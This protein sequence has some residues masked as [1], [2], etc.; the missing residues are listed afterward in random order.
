MR[1]GL[2]GAGIET[3]LSPALHEQEGRSHGLD[4]TYTLI[5]ADTGLAA[6]LERAEA[7]GFVGVNITHPFKQ[8]AV[9]LVDDLSPQA[10]EIGAVNTVV[11]DDG[12][13]TGHNTDVHGF[14]E[15]FRLNLPGAARD[16]V[17]LLGAG[18]AGAACAFAL[19]GLGVGHLTVVDP[20]PDRRGALGEALAARFDADRIALSAPDRLDPALRAA[21]GLVNASPVGM[22]SHPGLPLPVDLL[23]RSLW[24][25]DVIYMPVDTD[26]LVAAR[27]R[28]L[29]A[30]GGAAMCV[31][32]AAAA[33][34]LFTGRTPD[35]PRM[36]RHAEAL[37][38]TPG[39]RDEP[40]D[41]RSCRHIA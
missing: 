16:R 31:F 27:A 25:N 24:V 33:F 10:R 22:A 19:L 18:G 4:L 37:L 14:A 39:V 3:S 13:R 20:D 5:D 40:T 6:L 32:Q 29:R 35:T 36:L 23:H 7:D 1:C 21:D 12:R 15:S 34:E 41:R 9:A 30:V 8:R 17:V 2:I 28:G 11:F 26:L 38:S